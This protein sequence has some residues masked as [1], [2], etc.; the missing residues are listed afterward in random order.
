MSEEIRPI[1]DLILILSSTYSANSEYFSSEVDCT[2]TEMQILLQLH[3]QDEIVVK[4]LL[5]QMVSVTPSTLSR[6]FDRLE[7]R[8]WIERRPNSLDRR[9]VV[10]MLTPSGRDLIDEFYQQLDADV[11]NLLQNLPGD[12]AQRFLDAASAVVA[13][14]QQVPQQIATDIQADEMSQER[15]SVGVAYVSEAASAD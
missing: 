12:A 6:L 4:D 5:K 3:T 2:P 7:K 8:A 15:A 13:A 1:R 10:V 9:S 11:T 14:L